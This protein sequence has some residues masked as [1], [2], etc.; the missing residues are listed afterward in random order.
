MGKVMNIDL[1]GV[2]FVIVIGLFSIF[3]LGYFAIRASATDTERHAAVLSLMLGWSM[4][5]ILGLAFLDAVQK[6]GK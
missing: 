2:Y 1:T 5:A 6:G 4:F 3:A